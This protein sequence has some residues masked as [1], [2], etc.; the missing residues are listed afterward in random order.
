MQPSK[1][2]Q[3]S[4]DVYFSLLG[5]ACE[6]RNVSGSKDYDVKHMQDRNEWMYNKSTHTL[7]LWDGSKGGTRNYLDYAVAQASSSMYNAW[8]LFVS[9]VT[10]PG[11]L[12]EGLLSLEQYIVGLP[13]GIRGDL[14]RPWSNPAQNG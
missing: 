11:I 1:W 4:Q 14:P 7:A 10:V 9:A 12:D 5:Q 13:D 3:P 6:V 2:P 8:P